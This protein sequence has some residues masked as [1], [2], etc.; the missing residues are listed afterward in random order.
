MN[1]VQYRHWGSLINILNS[2]NTLLQLQSA[3][4]L[5]GVFIKKYPELEEEGYDLLDIYH[6]KLDEVLK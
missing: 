6:C 5:V 3:R 2:C 4:R 1:R